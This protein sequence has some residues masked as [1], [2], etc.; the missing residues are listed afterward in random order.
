MSMRTPLSK[1]RN[2]WLIINLDD[3]KLSELLIYS[4]NDWVSRLDQNIA[5]DDLEVFVDKPSIVE[6]IDFK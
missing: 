6:K 1:R 2:V 5:Q 4:A 3:R